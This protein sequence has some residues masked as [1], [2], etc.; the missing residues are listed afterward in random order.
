MCVCVCVRVGVCMRG[1]VCV[2][3]GTH[4]YYRSTAHN[5][6]QRGISGVYPADAQDR[7]AG[8]LVPDRRDSLQSHRARRVA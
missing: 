8:Q 2:G 4:L 1:C 6:L 7:E 5:K 3:K